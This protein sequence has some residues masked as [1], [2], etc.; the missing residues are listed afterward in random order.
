[1][2]STECKS[3]AQKIHAVHEDVV[4]NIYYTSGLNYFASLFNKRRV[5]LV[6]ISKSV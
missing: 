4:H 2:Y 1:M 3:Y 6:I 5:R